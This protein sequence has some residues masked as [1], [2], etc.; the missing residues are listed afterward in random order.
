VF[1]LIR[2]DVF[3]L[4]GAEDAHFL[5]LTIAFYNSVY[6]A[7]TQTRENRIDSISSNQIVLL[8]EINDVAMLKLI[9]FEKNIQ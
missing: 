7:A 5:H 9:V 4:R 8:I 6:C 3:V 2:N 1:A